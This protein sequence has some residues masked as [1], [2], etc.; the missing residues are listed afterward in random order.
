LWQ[1][2]AET[3]VNTFFQE[4]NANLTLP[5]ED[6]WT[7]NNGLSITCPEGCTVE[8]DAMVQVGNNTKAANEWSIFGV[9]NSQ[10]L[11]LRPYQGILPTNR[12]YV[13]GN[14]IGWI[15]LPKSTKPYLLQPGVGIA[16]GPVSVGNYAV[17]CRVYQP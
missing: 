3:L 7:F 14:Y 1:T 12:T 6:L 15:T 11:D 13:T 9:V 10:T 16:N 4:A 2:A 5:K 17:S 8:F